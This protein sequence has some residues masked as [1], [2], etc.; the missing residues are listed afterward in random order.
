MVSTRRA[1][2]A[3]LAVALAVVEGEDENG[4]LKEK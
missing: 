2:Y 3:K 4:Q 1:S